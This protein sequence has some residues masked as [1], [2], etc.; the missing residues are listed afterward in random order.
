[1]AKDNPRS[2][3]DLFPEPMIHPSALVQRM[4]AWEEKD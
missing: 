4:E 1:M 3:M 2:G